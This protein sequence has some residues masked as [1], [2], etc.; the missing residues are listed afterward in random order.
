MNNNSHF[1]AWIQLFVIL[2]I[3]SIILYELLQFTMVSIPLIL[4]LVTFYALNPIVNIL[5]SKGMSRSLSV[6]IVFL[7]S[8][9]VTIVLLIIVPQWFYQE[10]ITIK[11][12]FPNILHSTNNFI[13]S[14]ESWINNKLPAGMAEVNS[15]EYLKKGINKIAPYVFYN[16]P[17]LISSLIMII[18]LTPV[19]AFFFLKD[20]KE[21]K[22]FFLDV[23]PNK[24]FEMAA[25]MMDKVNDK[26]GNYIVGRLIEAVAVGITVFIPTFFYGIQ[27]AFLISF[28]VATT[29][30]VPYIGPVAG[31][32][33][34][35]VL[36]LAAV[37]TSFTPI[38]IIISA[39]GFAQLLDAAILSPI[40]VG[41]SMSLHPIIV[42]LTF[43]IAA[44][45]AGV[46]GLVVGV[47]IVATYVIILQEFRRA[48]KYFS[49]I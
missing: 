45:I 31:T 23:T 20:S 40:I 6:M 15:M 14:A 42:F 28:I 43:I 2:A 19:F 25:V 5:I 46:L 1:W 22:K 37:Q 4:G 13:V 18:A 35:A 32:V 48:L 29:N 24:Y 49:P 16:I 17:T 33:I 38:Y 9:A 44:K 8:S 30:I 36:G 12:K 26:V 3:S 47:P 7:F 10:L 41:K 34:A 21:F 27:G 11:E 39:C